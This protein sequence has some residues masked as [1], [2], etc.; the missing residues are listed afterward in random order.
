VFQEDHGWYKTQTLLQDQARKILGKDAQRHLVG[1]YDATR[2][3][4]KLADELGISVE[5]VLRGAGLLEAGPEGTVGGE[6]DRVV[7]DPR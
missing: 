3:A 5:D 1:V 7:E 4:R 6:E 2:E